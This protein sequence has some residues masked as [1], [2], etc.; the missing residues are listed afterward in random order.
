MQNIIWRSI[1]HELKNIKNYCTQF[2]AIS[3]IWQFKTYQFPLNENDLTTIQF[4]GRPASL[5]WV[6]SLLGSAAGTTAE[7]TPHNS[8]QKNCEVFISEFPKLG[9][10]SIPMCLSTIVKLDKS[11]DDILA[12]YSKSLRR[13]INKSL[14]KFRYEVVENE[15]QVTEIENS[16]LRP[17]AIARHDTG[18]HQFDS[19][20]LKKIA[21]NGYGRLDVLYEGDEQVG[22]H[23]GNNHVS[24]LKTYWH[25]NRLGYK[26]AIYTDF[27]RWGE[28]NSINLHLALSK[29]IE[30]G[31]DYCD[32]GA[33]LARPGK[34][35]IEWKRRRKG[36]LAQTDLQVCYLTPPKHGAAD[37]FWS[38]PL[39]SIK[40]KKISLHLG[41]PANKNEEEIAQKYK[42][43]GYFGL[44]KVF[45]HCQSQPTDNVIA[46]IKNLFSSQG[47]PPKIEI[48][49]GS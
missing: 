26:E 31:Y 23:F 47:A 29:A 34:G 5:A 3:K 18:A 33:S 39:F 19:E 24:R 10:L 46:S 40:R 8:N 15:M 41:L 48:R 28:V 1:K 7:L 38:A 27:P 42:E 49:I 37:F 44:S 32:Y 6:K 9:T 22:C 30:D 12:G 25:V 13:S 43:M 20:A 11:I 14:P 21:L 36:F 2:L 35:V 16:M 17:Y 4:S 45:L